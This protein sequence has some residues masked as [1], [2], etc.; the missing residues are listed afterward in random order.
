LLYVIARATDP[1]HLAP[2]SNLTEFHRTLARYAAARPTIA[3]DSLIAR[4]AVAC[5]GLPALGLESTISDVRR[6]RR[7]GGVPLAQVANDT[8][9][10]ISLLRE[11]EWGVFTNWNLE[12][13]RGALELYAER[14]GL[15]ADAVVS[16]IERE[17]I[18]T[19]V[20]VDDRSQEADFTP[21]MTEAPLTSEG[22]ALPL[23]LAALMMATVLFIGQG[24]RSAP[25]ARS[26]Q[27]PTIRTFVRS[28]A[29]TDHAPLTIETPR[30]PAGAGAE[31]QATAHL[32]P[33]PRRNRPSIEPVR[34]SLQPRREP[35][36]PLLRLA[37]TIAGDGRY[38]VE[39]FPK[40]K[41][42]D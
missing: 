11:L 31:Q 13:T 28:A 40:V 29:I 26:P 6:L 4:Y 17:L 21:P 9:I 3:M 10:P 19:G 30:H 15:D 37:R 41:T 20:T 22:R 1:R 8:A 23:A 33:R 42:Q 25:G 2:F 14:A 32:T 5:S 7:A 39:P 36:H 38:K 12:H 27:V 24:D 35:T 18:V 34:R 16:V